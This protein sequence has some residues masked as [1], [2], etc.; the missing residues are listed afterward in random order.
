MSNGNDE[1]WFVGGKVSK[2]DVDQQAA[3]EKEAVLP[4]TEGGW[5]MWEMFNV[6]TVIGDMITEEDR[7]EHLWPA[8]QTRTVCW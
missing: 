3:P 7:V 6:L 8:C 4:A 2:D 5:T 1:E